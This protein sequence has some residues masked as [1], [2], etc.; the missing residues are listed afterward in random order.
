MNRN[1]DI[2]IA[3]VRDLVRLRQQLSEAR[4]ASFRHAWIVMARE[5]WQEE[6]SQDLFENRSRQER[7]Q[8]S[9]DELE[10]RLPDFEY[11]RDIIPEDGILRL[12]IGSEFEVQAPREIL[13]GFV[14]PV[15]EVP[16]VVEITSRMLAFINIA[17][18][19]DMLDRH[20]DQGIHY[21]YALANRTHTTTMIC[22][23][24]RWKRDTSQKP[25]NDVRPI[26]HELH[27]LGAKQKHAR[28]DLWGRAKRESIWNACEPDLRTWPD[29]KA[30]RCASNN[31]SPVWPTN[32]VLTP[33]ALPPQPTAKNRKGR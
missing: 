14:V 1:R 26:F 29:I 30:F 8:R 4:E 9:L 21:H 23:D 12:A 27:G 10:S 22:W 2:E 11:D 33:K 15:R 17:G 5:H 32:S 31:A 24:T 18:E 25:S 28:P 3:A 19:K 6:G 16:I 13:R 7:L 20:L